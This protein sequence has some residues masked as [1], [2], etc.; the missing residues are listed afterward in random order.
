MFARVHLQ[1]DRVVQALA[2]PR[3]ALRSTPEGAR[4][5]VLDAQGRVHL[6]AVRVGLTTPESAQIL[7]GLQEGQKVVTLGGANLEDG[8][9][10]RLEG[11]GNARR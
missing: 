6:R 4:I 9:E 7:E 8:Q 10:V 5:A 2:V 3:S 11:T 1:V